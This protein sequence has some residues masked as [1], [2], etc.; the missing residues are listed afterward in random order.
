MDDFDGYV[1]PDIQ[2]CEPV[3]EKFAPMDSYSVLLFVKLRDR[4]SG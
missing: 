2:I 1:D 4:V 3:E